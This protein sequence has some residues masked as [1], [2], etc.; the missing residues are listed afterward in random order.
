MRVRRRHRVQL[1]A[2]RPLRGDEQRSAQKTV[3]DGGDHRPSVLLALV[4]AA[5][6][7]EARQLV[8]EQRR[9]RWSQARAVSRN[10]SVRSRSMRTSKPAWRSI[11]SCSPRLSTRARPGGARA[12]PVSR[13]QPR[14]QVDREEGHPAA[15]AQEPTE[16]SQHGE[17]AGQSTEDI[18]VHDG[19][20]RS[21]RER[22]RRAGRDDHRRP[23]GEALA[24]SA[25]TC[26]VQ[27][28]QRQIG[29]DDGAT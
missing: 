2:Q 19:V 5:R 23:V 18:G 25:R 12:A 17:L 14:R 6:G 21:R 8:G 3:L 16:C 1:V 26:F 11:E 24:L 9:I 4:E 29:T 10:A 22:Q 7:L 20:E 13:G 28:G 15:G 27:C